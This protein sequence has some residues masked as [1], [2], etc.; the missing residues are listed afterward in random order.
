MANKVNLSNPIIQLQDKVQEICWPFFKAFNLSSFLFRRLYQ[1]GR[2]ITL[3]TEI[4]SALDFIENFLTNPF[5]EKK[6]FETYGKVYMVNDKLPPV[7]ISYLEERYKLYDGISFIN[8]YEGYFDL[9]C[10]CLPEKCKLAATYYMSIMGE[11]KDFAAHFMLEGASLIKIAE[12]N[13]IFVSCFAHQEP[14]SPHL[15]AKC[16]FVKGQF[17]K[18][19]LK[20]NEYR[21][22]YYLHGWKTKVEASHLLGLPVHEIDKQVAFLKQKTGY[23]LFSLKPIALIDT[24]FA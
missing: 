12:E 11:L 20:Q 3:T 7:V 16:Y 5:S 8:L 13:P 1:D 9:F 15:D 19:I 14:L 24:C 17:G 23:P 22:L 6:N 18:V 10:F 21:L 2:L 4:N